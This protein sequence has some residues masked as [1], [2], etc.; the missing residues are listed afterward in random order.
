MRLSSLAER[1]RQQIPPD[2]KSSGDCSNLITIHVEFRDDRNTH[3]AENQVL[4]TRVTAA[5]RTSMKE[6]RVYFCDRLVLLVDVEVCGTLAFTD[7]DRNSKVD[8][9]G[10]SGLRSGTNHVS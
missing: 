6:I 7:C 10:Q 4:S 3:E 5:D 9:S 1:G 8:R 2:S